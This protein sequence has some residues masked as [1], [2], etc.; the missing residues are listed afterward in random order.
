MKKDKR[1]PIL[2]HP[3]GK[4]YLWGGNRLKEEYEKKIA[5]T[6]LAETWECSV[7]PDGPS[8]IASGEY[9]GLTLV[10]LLD[11]HPEYMGSKVDSEFPIL[12]KFIDAEKDLSVQVHPNDEY[13]RS[14][15]NQNGKTEVWYVLDAKPETTLVC[16]FAHDVTPE[17]LKHAVETGTLDK[18]MQKV[19]VHKGDV[20]FIPAGTVH[21]IGAGALI[22]E[23]QESSNVTYRVY[24]YNRED[25]NGNQRELHF[26]KAIRVLNMKAGAD[27]RQ[28]PRKVN[29]YY[30]SAREILC[31]C[32]YFEVERIQVNLGFDFTVMETSFQVVLC[33]NGEGG[34]AIDDMRRP[35]RF[36]KGDCVF[37]PADTGRCHVLGECE[38]LKIR[39]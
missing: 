25:K 19:P 20:F 37:V 16:G 23:I 9:K 4:D 39:C 30:G 12:V 26:D 1:Q 14:Y 8:V 36:K 5:L 3:V 28:K 15:E 34:V 27:V 7:H 38:L 24:D 11:K 17:I 18:H 6:P 13:A 10:Q 29:Y 31:R 22:A 33:I 21:A 32:K 2:L 35:L